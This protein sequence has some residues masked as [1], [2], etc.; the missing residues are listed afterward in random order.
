MTPDPSTEPFVKKIDSFLKVFGTEVQAHGREELSELEE[1]QL[2]RLAA[3]ELDDEERK[4]LIPLLVHN[5]QAMEYLVE[6]L[7]KSGGCIEGL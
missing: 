6:E 4:R 1:L 3:G 5:E 7:R 2:R